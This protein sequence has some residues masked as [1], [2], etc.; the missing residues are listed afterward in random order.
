MSAATHTFRYD[1]GR[2]A[3]NLVGLLPLAG[4]PV[5]LHLTGRL[6]PLLYGI[7][8]VGAAV[9]IA[10]VLYSAGRFKLAVDAAGLDVRGRLH[11]RTVAFADLR[12]V[13]IRRGRD[14][15]SRFMGPPPFRELVLRTDA[16]RL[17]VSSLP[18]G[19]ESFEQVCRLIAERLPEG[20]ELS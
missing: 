13:R 19:E 2:L 6:D 17:V 18:L 20:V 1:R 3:R 8:G 7:F 15:A 11:H 16:R 12:E 10:G 14:K 9:L 4:F 5:V